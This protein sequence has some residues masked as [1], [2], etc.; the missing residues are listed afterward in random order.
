MQMKAHRFFFIKDKIQIIPLIGKVGI[1]LWYEQKIFKLWIKTFLL[2][3]RDVDSITCSV[4][5]V[6][7]SRIY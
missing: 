7:D 2:F 1:G 4:E 5:H 3:L 6:H